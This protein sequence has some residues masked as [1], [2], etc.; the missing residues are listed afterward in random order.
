MHANTAKTFVIAL[1]GNS[2]IRANEKGTMEEQ[3]ANLRQTSEQLVELLGSDNRIVITHGNGPQVG[4]LLLASEATKDTVPPMT[5]DICGAATQ[6]FMGYMMQQTLANSLRAKGLKHDITTVVTQ[7]E[8]DKN[9]SAFKN[10]S[11]P[12]GPFYGE[13]EARKLQQE[14]G[15]DIVEDANRGYRR[16]VPSPIPVHIEQARIIKDMLDDGEIVVAV[17]GGGIPVVR[18]KDRSLHGVE[19]V[20]D[21]DFAS[22]CLALDIDA[23]VLIILTAVEHVFCDFG[24]PS[25]KALDSLDLNEAKKLLAEGHF[26]K[27]SMEPKIRAAIQFL[28]GGAECTPPR[29]R[30]VIITL[31]ETAVKAL[32]GKTGTRIT[33][34]NSK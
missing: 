21:K 18:E 12:I 7:V 25:Q 29:E 26:G 4:N 24:L 17:G 33:I 10:P 27:G 15:W 3:C 20:I 23:D 9:D 2:L 8:V 11:K 28:E 16:V 5:L 14:R 19:A 32:Q 30:E 1:G 22:S 31:P 13:S 34:T 6:G